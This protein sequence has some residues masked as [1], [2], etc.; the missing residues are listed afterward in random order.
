MRT[1]VAR[2]ASVRSASAALL[3]SFALGSAG[4]GAFVACGSDDPADPGGSGGD[5]GPSSEAGDEPDD[6]ADA[7]YTGPTTRYGCRLKTTDYLVGAKAESLPRPDAPDAP[8][9]NDPGNALSEDGKVATVTLTDGESEELRISG[10]GIDL[11]EGFETW[12]IEVELKRQAPDG[13]VEDG[14]VTLVVPGHTENQIDRKFVEGTWPRTAVGTHHYG[15]ALD[16]WKLDL[17]PKD[18]NQDGFAARLWVRKVEDAGPG[19][20]T[21]I[22]ESLKVAVWYCDDPAKMAPKD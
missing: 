2:G 19:P 11:D 1:S 18:V 3:L 14:H 21:A 13:G 5:G 15:Q 12:G 16:T 8:A 10:F 9:W 22:V 7:G 4:V 6:Q 17:F 20:V